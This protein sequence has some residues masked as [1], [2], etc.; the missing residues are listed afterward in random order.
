MHIK[1]PDP[2]QNT[3]KA[4]RKKVVSICAVELR[5]A[6]IEADNRNAQISPINHEL[7]TGKTGL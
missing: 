3:P 1:M 6:Q 2:I 7:T 4:S 5:P